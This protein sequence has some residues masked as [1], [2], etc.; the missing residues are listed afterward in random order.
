M[1][2]QLQSEL[3]VFPTILPVG[4]IWASN[5]HSSLYYLIRVFHC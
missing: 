4:S 5:P 2:P 3:P 1:L